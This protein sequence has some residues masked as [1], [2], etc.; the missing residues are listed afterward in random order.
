MFLDSTDFHK[1]KAKGESITAK[2]LDSLKASRA[3][4]VAIQPAKQI[5]M[6]LIMLYMSGSQVQI[7][8]M[9][10]IVML[11]WGPFVNSF[12][13][14]DS[15][16]LCLSKPNKS[17]HSFIFVSVR[18]IRTRRKGPKGAHNTVPSKDCFSDASSC[19]P[20]NWIVEMPA[21]GPSPDGNWRL[22]SLRDERTGMSFPSACF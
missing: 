2:S 13:V 8:S 12:K 3:W 21:N 4:S 14:N 15:T 5:P 18:T 7:F 11:L 16:S 17:I 9:G 19:W 10:V 22:V 1:P 20:S 6:N